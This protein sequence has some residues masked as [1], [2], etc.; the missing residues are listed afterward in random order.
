MNNYPEWWNTTI[1]VFNKYEDPA[2]RKVTW[3]RTVLENCFYK[4]TG[5]RIVVGETTIETSNTLCRIPIN[6]AFLEKYEWVDVEDKS[7]YFTLGAGD[8]IIKGNVIDDIDEY[9]AGHRS[10]DVVAKYKKMQGCMVI[11]QY[12]IS[13]G[14]GRGQEHYFVR[15][16]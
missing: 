4:N 8:I 11:E 9:V 14:L 2:T 6:S 3:Y 7:K 5:N 12:T 1:T 10:S 15:G 16:V 13:A